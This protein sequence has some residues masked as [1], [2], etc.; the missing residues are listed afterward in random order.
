MTTGQPEQSKTYIA[1]LYGMGTHRG[2][3]EDLLELGV[4]TNPEEFG[5]HVKSGQKVAELLLAAQM[6]QPASQSALSPRAMTA[7]GAAEHAALG[8]VPPDLIK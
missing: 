6:Q 3:S 2:D 4:P 1:A 5:S 7:P 8:E